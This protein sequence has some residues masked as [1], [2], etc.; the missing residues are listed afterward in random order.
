MAIY[1]YLLL[2]NQSNI[3]QFCEIIQSLPVSSKILIN[4]EAAFSKI[5][6]NQFKGVLSI[7]KGLKM[8]EDEDKKAW[9]IEISRIFQERNLRIFYMPFLTLEKIVK[10]RSFL[11][12][13]DPQTYL[14]GISQ[15]DASFESFERQKAQTFHKAPFKMPVLA[16]KSFELSVEP[17]N[18]L[19]KSFKIEKISLIAKNLFEK[20]SNLSQNRQENSITRGEI[21][22]SQRTD[23]RR[24]VT[25]VL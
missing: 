3:C 10:T 12:M 22:K 14:V 18:S 21:E 25:P 7:V 20:K 24:N 17:K 4:Q 11:K 8:K 13:P 19:L 6:I 5:S 23:S 1:I 9:F 15:N 2:S 16:R